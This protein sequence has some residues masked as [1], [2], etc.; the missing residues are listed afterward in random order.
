MSALPPLPLLLLLPATAATPTT[1]TQ[2]PTPCLRP[3]PQS[4]SGNVTDLLASVS[5]RG[6][7]N[8]G[9]PNGI[10][11]DCSGVP[12][13][14][15]CPELMP[16]AL[17]WQIRVIENTTFTSSLPF[18][19]VTFINSCAGCKCEGQEHGPPREETRRS[20]SL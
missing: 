20:L 4:H 5:Q 2:A 16:P 6:I 11:S 3:P 12:R 8:P 7:T 10:W 9:L 1:P 14:H 13:C 15:V 19:H 18:P 17:P